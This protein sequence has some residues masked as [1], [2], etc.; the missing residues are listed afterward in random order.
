MFHVFREDENYVGRKVESFDIH[1]C[2]WYSGRQ[3]LMM[4]SSSSAA[5]AIVILDL[6]Q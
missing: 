6:P 3:Q 2:R 1:D 4:M 5:I